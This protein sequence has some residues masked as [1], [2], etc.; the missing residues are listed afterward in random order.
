MRKIE[1]E[2]F[3]ARSKA[4]V[5]EYESRLDERGHVSND[6][7]LVVSKS[8]SGH[9]FLAENTLQNQSINNHMAAISESY[10]RH[11]NVCNETS[12]NVSINSGE[13]IDNKKLTLTEASNLKTR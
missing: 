9:R 4:I 12:E 1:N 6:N 7:N 3:E 11:S 8:S 5:A 13:N 10:I 2:A